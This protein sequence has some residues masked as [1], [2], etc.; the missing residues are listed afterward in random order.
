MDTV[1]PVIPET[2]ETHSESLVS[3][4]SDV[5]TK[6]E[7]LAETFDVHS[8]IIHVSGESQVKHQQ[9]ISNPQ[10]DNAPEESSSYTAAN[11]NKVFSGQKKFGCETCGKRFSCMTNLNRH[12]RMHTG[13]RPFACDQ[14]EK[15][16]SL[17]STL[18]KHKLLH[19]GEKPFSCNKCGK[20]YTYKCN[21]TYH[22]KTHS[23]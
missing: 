18:I 19:T 14:C 11:N 10:W 23:N 7:V 15:K 17:N 9:D 22:L 5:T 12:E 1:Y 6:T 4:Y 13:E 3:S 8:Q 20:S 2:C 21:L 16:F